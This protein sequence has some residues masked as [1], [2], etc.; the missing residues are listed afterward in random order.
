VALNDWAAFADSTVHIADE[1]G[2]LRTVRVRPANIFAGNRV[3]MLGTLAIR[4]G[5]P[6]LSNVTPAVIGQGILPLA[7][8]LPTLQAAS[9]NGGALDAALVRISQATISAINSVAGDLVLTVSDGS[10]PLEVVL[11]RD[12]GFSPGSFAINRVINA[13]GVLV[14]SGQSGRWVLKPRSTNDLVVLP[15]Q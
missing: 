9:A 5:Q 4:D 15:A 8:N 3:R 11:D 1:T 13:T 12:L 14:P 6:V 7:P 10:G 2:S